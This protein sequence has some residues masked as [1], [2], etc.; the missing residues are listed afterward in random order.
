MDSNHHANVPQS[1]P[2]VPFPTPR[3][4]VPATQFVVSRR[5]S[6]NSHSHAAG[7]CSSR[8]KQRWQSFNVI[9]LDLEQEILN[10]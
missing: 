8:E 10:S 2:D 7:T 4:P 3:Y 6:W 5:R 9:C 1:D